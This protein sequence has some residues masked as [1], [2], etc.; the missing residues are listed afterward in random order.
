[1][2]SVN[3][4]EE[5]LK[6]M[7]SRL[8]KFNPPG[9]FIMFI[10]G[11]IS[12][13]NSKPDL[14]SNFIGNIRAYRNNGL[15]PC[16]DIKSNIIKKYDNELVSTSYLQMGLASNFEFYPVTFTYNGKKYGGFSFYPSSSCLHY[17]ELEGLFTND[18]KPFLVSYKNGQ[19]S[20]IL[21]TEINNSIK[22]ANLSE[23]DLLKHNG[24]NVWKQGDKITNAVWNDYA[25]YLS[26]IHI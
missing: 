10:I 20:Q 9:D 25:E 6:Y 11:V 8:Y 1:M 24:R 7:E 13:D 22:K 2:A 21:N 19:T 14:T 17:I 18:F 3:N 16:I 12:V 26:L 4:I 5:R 23:V 15:Y